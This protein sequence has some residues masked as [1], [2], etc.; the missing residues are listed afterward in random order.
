MLWFRI[1][2][3]WVAH[4]LFHAR[5]RQISPIVNILCPQQTIVD[6]MSVVGLLNALHKSLRKVKLVVDSW[7]QD[8]PIHVLMD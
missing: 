5:W 1:L 7:L 3:L 2:A 8:I 4:H 6:V